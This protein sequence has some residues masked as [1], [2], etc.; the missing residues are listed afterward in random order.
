MQH[1]HRVVIVGAGSAAS[2]PHSTCTG[3]WIRAEIYEAASQF[4]NW[5]SASTCFRMPYSGSM[6]LG[7]GQP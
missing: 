2:R 7:L 6:S 5:A 4:R 3:T 1:K